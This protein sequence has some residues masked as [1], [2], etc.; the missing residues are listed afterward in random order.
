LN[1]DLWFSHLFMGRI[2]LT[3]EF[4]KKKEKINFLGKD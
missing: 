1:S 2:F 4:S 3:E